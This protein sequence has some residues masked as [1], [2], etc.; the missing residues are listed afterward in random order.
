MAM[1]LSGTVIR[2]FGPGMAVFTNAS[3][4]VFVYTEALRRPIPCLSSHYLPNFS[5]LSN[6]ASA[7]DEFCRLT[8]YVEAGQAA[9]ELRANISA[10]SSDEQKRFCRWA[11]GLQHPETLGVL[12]ELF[13]KGTPSVSS[14]AQVAISKWTEIHNY[15]EQLTH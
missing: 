12:N 10:K 13:E 4:N 15:L 1:S 3:G 2:S 6:Y 9:K 7:F 11:P 5:S 8:L 14:D